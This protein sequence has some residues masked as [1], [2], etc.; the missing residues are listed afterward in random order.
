MTTAQKRAHLLATAMPLINNWCVNQPNI[1]ERCLRLL[2]DSSDEQ[3]E[4][5]CR[6]HFPQM[7]TDA[8]SHETQLS[9]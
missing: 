3:L 6:E 4:Q 9:N 2:R 8:E 7:I 1:A 5:I